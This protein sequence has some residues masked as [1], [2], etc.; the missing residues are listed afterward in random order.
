VEHTTRSTRRTPIFLDETGRRWRR[1]RRAA[2][3]IGIIT[4][5]VAAITLTMVIIPPLL[6]E[7]PLTGEPFARPGLATSKIERERLSKK[8]QLYFTLRKNRV[9]GVH[10]NVLP[11]RGRQV[12][13]KARVPGAPI[14]AGFYV[15]W[16][17]NSL[18]ALLH[19]AD[20]LDWVV[21]ECAWLGA[22]GNGLRFRI[23]RRVAVTIASA[24]PDVKKRPQIFL[25]VSNFDSAT[26][27]WDPEGLRHLLTTPSSRALALEQLTDSVSYYGLGGVTI[28]FEEEPQELTES[29]AT[30]VAELRRRLA[31]MGKLVTQA[32]SVNDSD[33][34]LARFSQVNDYLFLML[35]DEHFGKT[36]DP[37]PIASQQWFVGRMRHMLRFVPPQ[38]AIPI[39]GAYGY[40]WNDGDSTTNGQQLTFQ[41]IMSAVRKADRKALHFDS[42][43][44]NPYATWTDR[45]STE[46]LSWYLDAI[47]AYNQTLAAQ[48]L[49]TAGMGIWRMG[50]EDPAIWRVIGKA[51]IDSSA[52]LLNVIPPGYDA[53]MEG[54]GEILDLFASPD[55][56]NRTIRID[57]VTHLVVD[58]VIHKVG[59]PY[60]V[61]R[62]GSSDPHLIALTFDD[63]PDGKWTPMILDTLKS[64]GVTGTFFLIGENAERHLPLLRRIVNEGHLIGN[65]TFLHPNLAFTSDKRTKLEL[66]ATERLFEAVLGRRTA[67]FRP[68]YF[69]D[70]EPTT[71]DELVP[72]QIAKERGYLIIGLHIDAEDWQSPGVQ[73]IIDTVLAQRTR[74]NVVLLHD[75][76]GDRSQTVAALGPLIDRLRAVGDTVVPLSQLIGLTRDQA[77]PGLPPRNRLARAGELVGWGTLSLV[78][79]LLYWIFFLAIF[80]GFAR[81]VFMTVLAIIQRIRNH[82][83]R[84]APITFAPSVSIIVPAYREEKVILRTIETLI[85]QEYP[86][87]LEVVVVDD[88]SPDETYEVARAAYGT[89]PKVR[90]F[91]KANGGKASALNY[92]LA[93]AS[94]EIVICLDADTLFAP[95][96]V[97]ELVE[98]LH[99]PKVGAVAGNAKVGN[100]INLVT[101]W[102]AIE[103]VTSQ[104]LD[105]RAFSL[106]N[107]ITV[108]P[109]AVG[110]WRKSLVQ[111]AGG[112]SE[113]TLAEDQDLTLSIR[114]RGFSIAYADEAIGYTEAPDTLRGLAKQRF[115]WS[116]GTL[117]CLWKHRRTFFHPRYGSLGFVALPNVLLFQIIYPF[118]SPIADLMF[119]LSLWSA[120]AIREAHGATY[121]MTSVEQVLTYYA[122]F[123][124]VDWVA[125]IIA[126]VLEPDEDKWLTWLIFLQRFAYRQVMYWVV[127][128]SVMAALRGRLVGWGK[129]ERKAT[130]EL[131]TASSRS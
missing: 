124:I 2:V 71:L 115:R 56:G 19:H 109:G 127:V 78:Q 53:E 62:Y 34:Q 25:M 39:V 75:G 65:H 110:A 129:L 89:H 117:Q 126:F 5:A 10:A 91:R 1:L 123:L 26:K 70:A 84:N 66:D 57:P 128:R 36:G 88:G 8:L 37:G 20:D 49:G 60:I 54:N 97:A 18:D 41:E 67:F 81:L 27:R 16:D 51:G 104:N 9:P 79:W 108:V 13:G 43:T 14:V 121:A 72:A 107:C 112:F 92:G 85:A 99:D 95:D 28:D 4:S 48:A 83:N 23:D 58:E 45:D 102:Q 12:P 21:C 32:A 96:T 73:T 63:G 15:T 100:R 105:R 40:D 31:P 52:A 87:E 7:I 114:R 74:G 122:V 69:G 6:P 98:P 131:E 119:V 3:V 94:G 42:T 116:F 118:L 82:Q 24:V 106:L 93:Y 125:S 111:K 29:I 77:M 47:T 103:Y 22:G 76:G 11:V 46:H 101:R 33:H 35:Y 90:I 30:F 61:N 80:L 130:V 55:S 113:D 120:W 86:G 59:T 64:R 44:L 17:D 68:P 50:S 38:K